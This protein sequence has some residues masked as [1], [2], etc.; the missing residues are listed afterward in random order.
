MHY[1]QSLETLTKNVPSDFRDHHSKMV[2]SADIAISHTQIQLEILDIG[3]WYRGTER[4]LRL[5]VVQNLPKL[6]TV[7]K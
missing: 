3:N 4:E 7:R 2:I 5:T 6:K 1:P